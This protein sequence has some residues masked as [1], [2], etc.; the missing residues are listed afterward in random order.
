MEATDRDRLASL[1]T[2]RVREELSDLDLLSVSELVDLMCVD[3]RRVP[4]ALVTQAPRIAEAVDAIVERMTRGGRLIYVGAGTAGRLGMLDA[5]EAGPTFNVDPGQVIG[6]LAGGTTA[7]EIPVENAE[8]D[9]DAGA[10][11]MSELT[12]DERDCVVGVSAS[13]RTPFVL[14]ALAEATRVG[15]LRIG[16]SCN[17]RATLS[18]HVDVPVEVVVGPEIIAG[19]TRMNSGTAQK[20]V[21]NIISTATMV[22]LGK[23]YGNL[24]V[25]LRPTNE[26]LRDRSMRIVAN[27]TASTFEDARR[28]LDACEWE[29][30]V[31]C[32]MISGGVTA[33]EARATLRVHD[34]RL[35]PALESLM[36]RRASATSDPSRRYLGVAAAFV[37]GELVAGDVAVANGKIVALGVPGVGDGVAVAGFVDAQVNGYAGVDLLHASTEE[38]ESLGVALLR[39][40]VVAYQ[41]TLITSERAVSEEAVRRLAEVRGRAYRGARIVG[42]HL[43]GPFLSRRRSGTHPV[44]HLRDPDVAELESLLECGPVTMVTL[45]P[46][47][48]GAVALIETCVRRGVTVSLGHS[49]ADASEAR[50]GFAAGARTVTHL[51]NAMEP[52]TARSAGLAGVALSRPEVVIQLIGDGVHVS[53]EMLRLAFAAAPDRCVVVSDSIAAA[54]SPE[55]TVYLGDVAVQVVDGEARRSDGTLAG[56][57]GRLRESVAHLIDIGIAPRE[58]LRAVISRPAELLGATDLVSRGV[59]TSADFFVLDEQWKIARRVVHGEDVDPVAGR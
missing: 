39:D 32:T 27:I 50:R 29:V 58:A 9:A 8:D 42:L 23:T 49:G 17:A 18:A 54:A 7:F 37:N 13:G 55:S 19:S 57:V 1:D 2:E 21:L 52:M 22:R 24:M 30:K 41:P 3:V 51:F 25:D 56:S 48:P 16:L 36:V 35:R 38:I 6:V 47:L 43:E 12:L 31:A 11:A 40:G 10:A 28:A 33:D 46:E 34:G 4:D 14:G 5:A 44:E 26:K 59:G 53:S 45:A 20:L 15:A